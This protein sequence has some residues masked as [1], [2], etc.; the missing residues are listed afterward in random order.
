MSSSNRIA[1]FVDGANLYASAKAL[2]FEIDYRRLLVDFQDRG[3]VL[4]ILLHCADRRSAIFRIP[5]H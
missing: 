2:G 3:T 1:L 5:G 4:R